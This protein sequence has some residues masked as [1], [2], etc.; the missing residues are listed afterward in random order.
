MQRHQNLLIN[1]LTTFTAR[2]RKMTKTGKNSRNVSLQ[3]PS[4]R[5]SKN[6]REGHHVST[7]SYKHLHNSLFSFSTA[8]FF[9]LFVRINKCSNFLPNWFF[10]LGSKI[11]AEGALK[12]TKL[13]NRKIDA[14]LFVEISINNSMSKLNFQRINKFEET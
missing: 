1:V 3:V 9:L 12:K 13:K 7:F 4:F 8:S 10:Q 6:S 11:L 14:F 5:E 2:G